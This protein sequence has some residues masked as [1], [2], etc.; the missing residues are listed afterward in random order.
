MK[1]SNCRPESGVGNCLNLVFKPG[2]DPESHQIYAVRRRAEESELMQKTHRRSGGWKMAGA[3]LVML[4]AS[5]AS[6]AQVIRVVIDE[7]K[8]VA[9]GRSFGQAGTYEY[10]RG[11]IFG[12]VDP[13]DPRNAIIQVY[14]CLSV[15]ICGSV[16]FDFL[17]GTG[18]GG[19][20]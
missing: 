16:L 19:G 14:Q 20:V 6:Q 1:S 5:V 7:R 10:I 11:R 4:A 8:P 18:F 15:F 3:A 12:E 9:E 2:R 17:V 13:K